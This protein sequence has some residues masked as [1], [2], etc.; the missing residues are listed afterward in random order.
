LLVLASINVV[1][2]LDRNAFVTLSPDIRRTFH[3]S[4]AGING[5][6]GVSSILVVL[7]ALPFA[8]LADRGARVRLAWLAALLWSGLTFLTSFVGSAA[9]LTLV[10]TSSGVGQA[11]I[12]PVHSSLLSDYYPPAARG[13]V[14]S[15]HQAGIPI[16]G[17]VGPALA[18]G[19]ATLVG[20]TEGWRWAF[21]VIAPMGLVVAFLARRLRE[22]ER[23]AVDLRIDGSAQD[24][25]AGPAQGVPFRVGVRQ[26]LAIPSLRHI[27]FAIGSLGF[28]LVSA[29]V[30]L[31]QFYE[32]QLHLDSLQ[33]GIV[34]AIGGVGTFVGL[35]IGGIAADNL[36]RRNPGWSLYV[37]GA[38]LM[39][40]AVLGSL[41]LYLP[42]VPAIVFVSTLA[43]LGTG[44]VVAPIRQIVAAASPLR[45]RAL[46]FA[47]LGIFILLFGGFLGGIVLGSIADAT[48]TRTALTLL[49]VPGVVAG[50]I[51]LR[52]SRYVVSDIIAA[53]E[54]LVDEPDGSAAPSLLTIRNLDFSY[55]NTQVLFDVSVDVPAGE[56]VALLGTNGAGKSTLLRAVCGLE[57]PTR[58]SIVFSG[59]EITYLGAESVLS[60]GI[61]QMPGGKAIFPGLTVHENLLT[62]AYSFRRDKE[63]VAQDIAQVEQWFPILRERR[64]QA[65]STLSGGEQQMLALSKA[66]L[67]R[68]KLL[69]IDELSLG[70]AP[71]VVEKLFGIVKEIHARGTTILIVEQSL[72]VALSLATTATFMEKG[73]VRFSG[74][75]QELLE[76]PDIVRSIFLAGATP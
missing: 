39:V 38:G 16:A 60:V 30:L 22:P 10:R 25:T 71:A 33:R 40:F 28:G 15:T 70:L 48:S 74:P 7:A 21:A 35:V 59:Q 41:C 73:Q 64:N 69:C 66:F 76:R 34:F 1:D 14:F 51:V 49:V 31:S 11:A 2:N 58:G 20:G 17:I 32:S 12:E 63:R 50:A 54:S 72:N 44:L 43:N 57:H 53:A 47:M 55:G 4:Q 23:G 19:V 75:A 46:A 18:G 68:P 9:Q 62:G 6:A 8:I 27:Y 65:A 45:L 67:T 56:V 37:A 24:L 5:I 13:R 52:G 36:F 3:L 29:P 61:T 26:L 42:W